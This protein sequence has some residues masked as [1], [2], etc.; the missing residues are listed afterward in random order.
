MNS[1]SWW[2][3]G[4]PGVLRFMGS[5]RVGYDWA[6]ELNWTVYLHWLSLIDNLLVTIYNITTTKLTLMQSIELGSPFFFYEAGIDPIILLEEALLELYKDLFIMVLLFLLFVWTFFSCTINFLNL[7]YSS[8]VYL[9]CCVNFCC[10]AK[11]FRYIKR[12]DS[13]VGKESAFNAGNPGMIPGLG[14]SIAE[15]KGYSL[16]YSGLENSMDCIVHEVAKGQTGL[17]DFHFHMYTH[18]HTHTHSFS[19]CFPLWFLTGYWI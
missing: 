11:W 13:S 6:T 3:T 15:G 7:L 17:S 5:Q 1:G 8:M 19:Y 14:R 2:W 16:Q 4:R 9:Q 12:Y 18:T 10:T